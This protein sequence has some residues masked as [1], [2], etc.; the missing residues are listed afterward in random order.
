MPPK[1]AYKAQNEVPLEDEVPM[2]TALQ[3]RIA[4]RGPGR[5]PARSAAPKQGTL[6]VAATEKKQARAGVAKSPNRRRSTTKTPPKKNPPTKDT[7]KCGTGFVTQN[8]VLNATKGG[9]AATRNGTKNPVVNKT[10]GG[11]V[12]KPKDKRKTKGKNDKKKKEPSP[13]PETDEEDDEDDVDVEQLEIDEEEEEEEEDV[14]TPAPVPVKQK[15]KRRGR[16][17]LRIMTRILIVDGGHVKDCDFWACWV[18]FVIVDFSCWLVDDVYVKNRYPSL[19]VLC[20]GLYTS[21]ISDLVRM[22]ML[23]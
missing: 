15:D 21:N 8:T 18:M 23:N 12:A 5:E 11:R 1:K 7:G 4:N 13:E 6:D 22:Y 17:S 2:E 14:P 20:F 10:K 19:Y 9:R 16:R 3:R